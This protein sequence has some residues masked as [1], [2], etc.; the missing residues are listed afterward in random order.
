MFVSEFLSMVDIRHFCCF[1]AWETLLPPF[2]QPMRFPKRT[3]KSIQQNPRRMP[4]DNVGRSHVQFHLAYR[5][6]GGEKTPKA[7]YQP[8]PS[9]FLSGKCCRGAFVFFPKSKK[10]RSKKHVF[11]KR[12]RKSSTTIGGVLKDSL[13]LILGR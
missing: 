6:L 1:F 2:S 9:V 8:S 11:P 10:S 12:G 3:K 13:F 7:A 4:A 5:S